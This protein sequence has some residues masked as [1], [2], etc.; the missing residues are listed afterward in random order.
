MRETRVEERG[1]DKTNRT[2][3]ADL[4]PLSISQA[5]AEEYGFYYVSRKTNAPPWQYNRGGREGCPKEEDII[6]GSGSPYTH[7]HSPCA[8]PHSPALRVD[9]GKSSVEEGG[10]KVSSMQKVGVFSCQ[11]SAYLL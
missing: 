6:L 5:A 3:L 1:D 9:A 2:Q 11:G 10:R 7:P 8:H 4:S